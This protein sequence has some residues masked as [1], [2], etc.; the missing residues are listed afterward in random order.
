[1]QISSAPDPSWVSEY[2]GIDRETMMS[3]RIGEG[4]PA[5]SDVVRRLLVVGIASF[6]LAAIAAVRVSDAGP[7]FHGTPYPD[8]PPAPAF[9]LADHLGGTTSLDDHR[10]RTVLLFFG[11]TRCPDVCPLTLSR[12]ARV[13]E[14]MGLGP[15]RLS[16]LFVT[17]DPE[18]DTEDRLADYVERFDGRVLGLRPEPDALDSL[19]ADYGVFAQPLA[20]HDGHETFAHTDLVFG[21]DRTGKLRVLI[22]ADAPGDALRRDLRTLTRIRR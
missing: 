15:D 12:L 2:C 13:V 21:I 19:L 5:D 20:G 8:A 17:V 22:H 6:L 18:H 16:V 3:N 14:E 11:F 10:G 1:V 7:A 4:I 9:S